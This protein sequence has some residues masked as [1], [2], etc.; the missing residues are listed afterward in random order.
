[1]SLTGGQWKSGHPQDVRFSF[2]AALV[3]GCL[4]AENRKYRADSLAAPRGRPARRKKKRTAGYGDVRRRV[5]FRRACR[6]NPF[7]QATDMAA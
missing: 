2:F 3:S 6:K 5:T 4:V 1:P 7:D